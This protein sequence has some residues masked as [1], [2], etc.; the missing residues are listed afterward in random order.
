M[1]ATLNPG[2]EVI[3]P[4]PFWTSYADM[5]RMAGGTPVIL[6]CPPLAGLQAD[7]RTTL[8]RHHAQH[9]LG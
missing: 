2:D 6:P 3:M 5:V 4:A 8:R 7:A 9:P 1:L